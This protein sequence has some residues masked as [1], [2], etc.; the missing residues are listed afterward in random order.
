MAWCGK[1]AKQSGWQK[2]R[3]EGEGTNKT[4]QLGR[5]MALMGIASASNADALALG[6]NSPEDAARVMKWDLVNPWRGS[7]SSARHTR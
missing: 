3:G 6:T 4:L 7:M 1:P 2:N 5:G